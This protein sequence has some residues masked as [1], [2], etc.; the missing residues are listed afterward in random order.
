MCRRWR[1]PKNIDASV[2]EGFKLGNKVGGLHERTT[3]E[4][5]TRKIWKGLIITVGAV[6]VST[7]VG[8][9]I[10]GSRG[11]LIGFVVGIISG[12]ILYIVLPAWR[13]PVKTRNNL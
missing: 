7:V 12:A 1:K 9:I 2:V 13:Y 5:D 4:M 10:G 8:L 3:M 11:T 6:I